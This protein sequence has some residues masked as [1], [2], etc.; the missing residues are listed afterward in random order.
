M[1]SQER[2]PY[3][4]ATV[5][6]C[7][8]SPE[9]QVAFVTRAV[10]NHQFSIDARIREANVQ[11]IASDV[12]KFYG[13]GYITD[14]VREIWH[15]FQ[16]RSYDG[17]GMTDKETVFSATT[18][19]ERNEWFITM[20]TLSWFSPMA[21]AVDALYVLKL[22]LESKE[23]DIAY[24]TCDRVISQF[25]GLH[26]QIMRDYHMPSNEHWSQW[27]VRHPQYDTALLH[28]VIPTVIDFFTDCAEEK[29]ALPIADAFHLNGGKKKYHTMEVIFHSLLSSQEQASVNQITKYPRYEVGYQLLRRKKF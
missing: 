23:F 8:F 25:P 5:S 11:G 22:K 14:D 12:A 13:L 16:N 2:S 19:Q 26:E 4:L 20:N 10:E 3:P 6:L 15:L 28:S 24:D 29:Q 9:S 18:P 21:P 7:D 27:V 1:L 17:T